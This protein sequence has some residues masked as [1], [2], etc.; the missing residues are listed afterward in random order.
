MNRLLR[1]FNSSLLGPS[2]SQLKVQYNYAES[3]G[4]IPQTRVTTLAN[5]F[6]IAS[7]SNPNQVTATVG[8]W[9]DAGSRFETKE[10]NGVAH[11]LE[12]M[13][14]KVVFFRVIKGN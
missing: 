13:I 11:F 7:E 4:K 3:L 9:L 12:H 10:N 2:P 1:R 5:G 14:F 6:R 8:I